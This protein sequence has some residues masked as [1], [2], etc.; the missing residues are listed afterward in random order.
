M[1]KKRKLKCLGCKAEYEYLKCPNC[2][3]QVQAK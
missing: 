1:T 3:S 2:G